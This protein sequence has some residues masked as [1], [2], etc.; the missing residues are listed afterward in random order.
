LPE[1]VS[2]EVKS[3]AKPGVT[4]GRKATDPFNRG[5][6]GYLVKLIGKEYLMKKKSLFTAL[7]IIGLL[8]LPHISMAKM[9]V[10]ADDQLSEVVGQAGIA[11]DV[12]NLGF[13]MSIGSLYW[14]DE[15]GLGGLTQG[16][17]LSLTDVT[18]R[19]NIDFLKPMTIDIVSQQTQFGTEVTSMNMHL[20]D[21]SIDIDEF[22]IDAIRL[23]SEPGTGP[24][25][26]SFGI[27][28]MH[29]DIT[30]DV[31]ISTRP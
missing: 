9:S 25:L 31:Q 23:G 24:S 27:Y 18:L 30:G 15:D 1:K 8:M 16:G 5:Q 17:Y 14:G 6:P 19:G 7:C 3:H 2:T 22:T 10:L 13:D 20:S 28:G 26:G 12:N 4:L 21:M 29:V 11:I